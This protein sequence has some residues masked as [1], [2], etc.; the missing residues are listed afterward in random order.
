LAIVLLETRTAR[1][2]VIDDVAKAWKLEAS[3]N[4]RLDCAG[5]RTADTLWV[6]G[7][8]PEGRTCDLD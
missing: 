8:P 6:Q 3:P 1:C 5:A 4:H 7:L 2:N